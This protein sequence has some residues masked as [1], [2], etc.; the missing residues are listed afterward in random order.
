MSTTTRP[1]S[2]S[3]CISLRSRRTWA[4]SSQW[5]RCRPQTLILPPRGSSP[6]KCQ[7]LIAHTSMWIPKQVIHNE[8]TQML[9]PLN[10]YFSTELAKQ[11][12]QVITLV[13]TSLTQLTT[14]AKETSLV[15]NGQLISLISC[16]PQG[17]Q[18]IA[19]AAVTAQA[20][21]W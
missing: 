4:R 18:I 19:H 10:Q 7:N 16:I 14:H 17:I 13:A 9:S 15:F 3:R 11:L 1:N 5:S 8:G 20:Y 21:H 2:P 12:P 6:S